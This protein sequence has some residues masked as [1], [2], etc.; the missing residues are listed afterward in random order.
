M[1]GGVSGGLAEYFDIDATI[2][3]VLFIITIFFGGGGI[4]AYIIL[5]I[6]ISE[7]PFTIQSP[8][9]VNNTATENGTEE[10][11]NKSESTN[12]AGNT[13]EQFQKSIALRK[14]NTTLWS[15][16]ILIL[17]GGLFLMDNFFPRF[18]FGD[19]WPVILIGIGVG[20]LIKSKNN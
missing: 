10:S 11:T 18:D 1:I 17:L 4:I 2:I 12:T 13:F 16:L 5:W 3:R 8:V 19:Y 6:V 15:G 20:L 7:K 9:P 14:Q